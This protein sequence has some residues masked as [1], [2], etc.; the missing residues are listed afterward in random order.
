M[1]VCPLREWVV[2]SRLIPINK[3]GGGIRPIAV[4]ES[5][6][7]LAGQW[8]LGLFSSQVGESLLP[9]QFGVGTPG[10][11]EPI[12][13]GML[14]AFCEEGVDHGLAQLDFTNAFN[15][16]S[17]HEIA[18]QL[19]AKVPGMM[20]LVRLLYNEPSPLLV[21]RLD[22]SVETIWSRR[23][24]R[25]GDPLAPFLFSLAIT[26]LLEDLAPHTVHPEAGQWA[27]L[28]DVWLDL[29]DRA[30]FDSVLEALSDPGVLTRFGLQVNQPKC[31]FY[32][33][34]YIRDVGI[35]AL[36][37]WLG[38]PLDPSSGG[39][40]LVRDAV[41]RLRVRVTKLDPLS[42]QEQLLIIRMC[43]APQLNHLIRTLHPDIVRDGCE[44][45]DSVVMAALGVITGGLDDTAVSIA[46]LPTRFGGLGV[47]SQ[48]ETGPIALGAG[49]LLSRRVLLEHGYSVGDTLSSRME[50]FVK[51]CA[52]NIAKPV[53]QVLS[54]RVKDLFSLQRRA[55]EILHETR[56]ETILSG[57]TGTQQVIQFV[58]SSGMMARP[59]LGAIPYAKHLTLS[60]SE[61][62]YALCRTLLL[63][64]RFSLPASTACPLCS[65]PS[66]P[67]HHLV[68]RKTQYER[69]FRHNAVRR[70]IARV[71]SP[72]LGRA[73]QEVKEGNLRFD[74]CLKPFS[75]ST[76]RDVYDV[77]ISAIPTRSDHVITPP[78]EEEISLMVERL[79]EAPADE[80]DF[81]WE[82]HSKEEVSPQV[83]QGRAFRILWSRAV[84]T[85]T[86]AAAERRK[87]T[88][89]AKRFVE[90]RNTNTTF[91]PFVLTA[92]GGVSLIAGKILHEATKA[93]GETHSVK[94]TAGFRRQ[95]RESVSVVLIK[96][97]SYMAQHAG[98]RDVHTDD[99]WIEGP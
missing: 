6:A 52:T 92:G 96:Y 78:S 18:T 53:D 34:E 72:D 84:V 98:H 17:R 74:I 36:G 60:D 50:H 28:D 75:M 15:S 85:P 71:L 73:E 48:V 16:I 13:F 81:A 14:S 76:Q 51:L 99:V 95:I 32:S 12:I 3:P 1:G 57:L 44:A 58:E 26:P 87:R 40:G 22:G 37:S 39:A 31:G 38:G 30:A 42:F 43:Y 69:T 8:V 86:V 88:H 54:Y 80:A 83:L 68:C 55:S 93:Y 29:P 27:Y 97:A 7:R 33:Q 11:V 49:F 90:P 70:V 94:Q 45:F 79:K 4:G 62:H 91:T 25:Q 9:S 41:E 65:K 64:N 66:Y 46:H 35:K 24:V 23:G 5:F 82:D 56:W 20:S 21:R 77:N 2:A 89:W 67:R 10:G 19:E 61:C 63:P 47:M 59:W